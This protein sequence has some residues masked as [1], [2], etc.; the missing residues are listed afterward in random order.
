VS[1]LRTFVLTTGIGL[2]VACNSDLVGPGDMRALAQAQAKWN[3]RGF[4]DYSYEIK[5]LC[6]CPPEINQWARV[7]VRAGVVVDVQPVETDPVYPTTYQQWWQPIDSL[8]VNIHRHMTESSLQSAYAAI[9][10]TYDDA[11][12]YPTRIEYRE[13]PTVA[14]AGAIITV[15]NVVPLN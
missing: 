7:T 3:A 1:L 5:T 9:I 8:F 15:R 11:L 2:A 6:F 4:A 14:D 12:G 13:K 10:V